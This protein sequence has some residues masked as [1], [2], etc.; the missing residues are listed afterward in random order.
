MTATDTTNA[1]PQPTPRMAA[2]GELRAL[3]ARKNF[4]RRSALAPNMTG[5]A[6]KNVNSATAVRE[7]PRMRPPMMVEP[8]REVPGTMESTWKRPMPSAVFQ[9]MSSTVWMRASASASSVLEGRSGSAPAAK[10]L[11]REGSGRAA[12]RRSRTVSITMNAMP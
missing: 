10:C 12:A 9:S 1:T 7:Q 5:M 6:R 11:P 8:E 3:P 4:T 2:S